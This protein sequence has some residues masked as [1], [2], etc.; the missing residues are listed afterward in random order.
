MLTYPDFADLI[1]VDGNVGVESGHSDL[2]HVGHSGATPVLV[3]GCDSE[4]SQALGIDPRTERSCQ[5]VV[6]GALEVKAPAIEGVVVRVT[7]QPTRGII[8]GHTHTLT[9]LNFAGLLWSAGDTM[10]WVCEERRKYREGLPTTSM[11][12]PAICLSVLGM[13]SLMVAAAVTRP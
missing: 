6:A 7:P 13:S 4:V 3:L 1:L 9:T 10:A 2:S 12:A 11:S 5:Q 8:V